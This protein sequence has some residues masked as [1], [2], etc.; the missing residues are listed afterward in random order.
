MGN[1]PWLYLVRFF[2]ATEYIYL[3]QGVAGHVAPALQELAGEVVTKVLPVLRNIFVQRLEALGHV[4]EAIGQFVVARQLLSGHS[5]DVR[6]WVKE[7][8]E[9]IDQGAG[10]EL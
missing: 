3:S 7:E 6:C 2:T 1:A 9:S 5:I 8:R 4:Q 10:D